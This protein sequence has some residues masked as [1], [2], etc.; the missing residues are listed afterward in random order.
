M[1][2]WLKILGTVTT[3]LFTGKMLADTLN[4]ATDPKRPY[5][6]TMLRCCSVSPDDPFRAHFEGLSIWIQL[7]LTNI[8]QFHEQK[9]TFTTVSG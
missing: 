1:R 2:L 3:L 6:N 7:D 5:L 8:L 9:H 4:A